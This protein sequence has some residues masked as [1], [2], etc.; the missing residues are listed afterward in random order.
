SNLL[1]S[2]YLGGTGGDVAYST[3]AD[4]GG[5]AYVTGFTGSG[6]VDDFPVT[7]GAFDP[8]Y[9]LYDAFVAKLDISSV[10]IPTD[11]APQGLQIRVD[12][13]G[14]VAPYAFPCINGTPHTLGVTSPQTPGPMRY[15]FSSWSDAGQQ[16]HIVICSPERGVR[17]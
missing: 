7:P 17:P 8:T 4:A 14:V 2:T 9:N 3:T 11:T 10:E 5:N 6:A 13:R 12:G 16:T 15:V 1:Y